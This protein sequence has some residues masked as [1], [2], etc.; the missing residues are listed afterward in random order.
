MFTTLPLCRYNA[1]DVLRHI[2]V[3]V[4]HQGAGRSGMYEL[5]G[6][7]TRG[8]CGSH[9]LFYDSHGIA[10]DSHGVIR[11]AACCMH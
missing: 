9:A 11:Q 2:I 7:Q 5:T 8:V 6:P 1:D 10:Y 4:R 3:H